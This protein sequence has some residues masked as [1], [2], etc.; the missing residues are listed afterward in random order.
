MAKNNHQPLISLKTALY[1]LIHNNL[2]I[3]NI[4]SFVNNTCIDNI[5][6]GFAFC[7][8]VFADTECD[9][10]KTTQS[11]KDIFY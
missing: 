3:L 1:I 9:V 11:R 7:C 10:L 2:Q 5:I 6:N 8:H 4:K